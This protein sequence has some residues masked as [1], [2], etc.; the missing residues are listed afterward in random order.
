MRTRP[1]TGL[2]SSVAFPALLMGNCARQGCFEA[3]PVY[4]TA[5]LLAAINVEALARRETFNTQPSA[6]NLPQAQYQSPPCSSLGP[7]LNVAQP[8]TEP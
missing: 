3:V 4:T 5:R 2:F 6:H 1:L 7:N 8:L